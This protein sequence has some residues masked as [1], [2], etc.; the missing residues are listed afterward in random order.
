MR[1]LGKQQEIL[2]FLSTANPEELWEVGSALF[3]ER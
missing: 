2:H 1:P 3:R